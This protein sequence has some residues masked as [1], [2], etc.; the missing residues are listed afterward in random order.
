MSLRCF[1]EPAEPR[2]LWRLSPNACVS[3]IGRLSP[4]YVPAPTGKLQHRRLGPLRDKV[5]SSTSFVSNCK[6]SAHR[7]LVPLAD[8]LRAKW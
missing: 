7:C 4:L 3:A 1:L 6:V 5:P 8:V 2:P